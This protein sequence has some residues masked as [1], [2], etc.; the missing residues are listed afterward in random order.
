MQPSESTT[1]E[2]NALLRGKSRSGI[3]CGGHRMGVKHGV[4]V[5]AAVVDEQVHG[6]L[7]THC[8]GRKASCRCRSEMTRSSGLH[9][10]FADGGGRGKNSMRVQRHGD[11]AI[12]AKTKPCR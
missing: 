1:S 8:A 9:H 10:A 5:G 7:V 6:E 11:V 2:T 4:G 3:A 12:G